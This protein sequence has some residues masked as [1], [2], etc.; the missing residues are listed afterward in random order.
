MGRLYL[1]VL[2]GAC[3][4]SSPVVGGDD[5]QPLPDSPITPDSPPTPDAMV[6]Q[7]SMTPDTMAPQP[8]TSDHVATQDTWIDEDFRNTPHGNDLALL[9]DGAPRLAV[10]LMR[11]DLSG[12]PTTST[13]VSAELHIFTTSDEGETV[14]VFP[15]LESWSE[16]SATYNARS[17]GVAWQ[18]TGAT[19]PSRGTTMVAEFRPIDENTEFAVEF[20]TNT[21]QTWV[22]NPETNFGIAIT[23]VDANGPFFRSRH[24]MNGKPFLHITHLP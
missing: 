15:M 13:I 23:S 7:D 18:G 17:I 24:V 14:T 4:Y 9:T 10:T 1:L 3:S 11:F 12:L 22:T 8:Q 6:S 16:G 21:V 2:L 20:D 19:P 5:D